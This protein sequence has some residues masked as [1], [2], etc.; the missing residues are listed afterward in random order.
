MVTKM[1]PV[2]LVA[3]DDDIA[4]NLLAALQQHWSRCPVTVVKD[5][6]A[7]LNVLRGQDSTL[8]LQLPHLILLVLNTQHRMDGLAFLQELRQDP[9]LRR[10]PVFVL[11]ASDQEQDIL[12]AYDFHVA[13]YILNTNIGEGCFRLIEL[14]SAYVNIVEFPNL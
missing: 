7:A 13:G 2:L 5:G 11:S 6:N 12:A 8:Y 10:R 14:L 4:G 3:P 9:L 1:V